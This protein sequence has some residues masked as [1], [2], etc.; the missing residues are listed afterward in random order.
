MAMEVQWCG[1]Q[2]IK[3]EGSRY[4][5]GPPCMRGPCGHNVRIRQ[6]HG[7][8]DS[9]F[10]ILAGVCHGRHP[11][12][13]AAGKLYTRCSGAT[14]A[15]AVACR[16]HARLGVRAV[17]K[18]VP[19]GPQQRAGDG[20]GCWSG[21]FRWCCGCCQEDGGQGQRH[22]GRAPGQ[23]PSPADAGRVGGRHG[24]S[25]RARSA[26]GYVGASPGEWEV[27]DFQQGS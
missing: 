19:P 20:G 25:F 14:A 7:N 6:D 11:E 26:Y 3:A 9:A 10:A 8:V 18:Q 15:A 4:G 1:Q 21:N 17:R 22:D 27:W 5:A 12:L 2:G 16:P 24:F 13:H 23:L